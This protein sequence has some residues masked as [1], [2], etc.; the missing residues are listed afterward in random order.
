MSNS[1][2]IV[3]MRFEMTD[4]YPDIISYGHDDW[5]VDGGMVEIS[6]THP[7][8]ED[9]KSIFGL[10]EV[11]DEPSSDP[12]HDDNCEGEEVEK[13][14]LDDSEDQELDGSSDDGVESDEE[15]RDAGEPENSSETSSS[16]WESGNDPNDEDEY[17]N[18]QDTDD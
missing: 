12:D 8:V 14:T 9:I 10:V 3:L 18:F 4:T 13:N 7:S 2:N 11:D 1:V 17:G 6:S 15:D 16:I 5:P